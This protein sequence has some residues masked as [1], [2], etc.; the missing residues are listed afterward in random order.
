M[1]LFYLLIAAGTGIGVLA[2]TELLAAG[3]WL[4]GISQL[5]L[6]LIVLSCSVAYVRQA[7]PVLSL[8]FLLLN[9]SL[10]LEI[11][12][13]MTGGLEPSSFWAWL[14]F[15]L[16]LAYGPFG[17][18]LATRFP[19]DRPRL[20]WLAWLAYAVNGMAA[21]L[22][23]MGL[24]GSTLNP[25]DP[26]SLQARQMHY[27]GGGHTIHTMAPLFFSF[28]W[29]LVSL[30]VLV[31]TIRIARGAG[32]SR[33]ARQALIIILGSVLAVVPTVAFVPSML[34]KS[35]ELILHGPPAV[36]FGLVP[37][38]W[39]MAL[40]HPEFYDANGLFRRFLIGLGLFA[41]AYL[42]YLL[43]IKTLIYLLD[44]IQPSFAHDPALFGAALTVALLIRPLQSWMANQV[45]RLFFPHLLGF[46]T[47]LEETSQ[48]L[49]T[50]IIPAEVAALATQ[51]L[52][53][54]LGASGATLLV[55]D[56]LDANLA[57]M[58]GALTLAPGHP[59]WERALQ[60]GAPTRLM[61]TDHS[62]EL[63]LSAPLLMLPLRVGGRL[64]GIYAVGARGPGLEYTKS[65]LAQL[66]VL[67]NQMAVAVE[68]G[69]ALRKIDALSQ[70]ALAEVAERNRIARDIH[71]TIAQGLTAASLQLEVVEA[72][73][74]SNQAKA[75][76]ATERAQS[77]VRANLAEARRSVLELRAPL[78][79]GESLPAALGRLL[80][81]AAT[82]I[83][84]SSNFQLEGSYRGVEARVEQQ[85]FRI[86]QEALHNAVKYSSASHLQMRLRVAERDVTLRISD[87]GA[88]FDA[89]HVAPGGG[90]GG[91]GLTGMGE[92][93][94]LLGGD[95][96]VVSEPGGGT[97]VEA[98]IPLDEG[99]GESA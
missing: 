85:L 86:A 66:M 53:T 69:R 31:S 4:E 93:A 15:G 21:L 12:G 42:A 1:K 97:L 74:V 70:R 11:A 75:L 91:F 54:R 60:A 36:F 78:L 22:G 76:R 33:T 72:T 18:D 26:L 39:T 58:D 47:L 51:S 67:G 9:W 45:D 82:D 89:A 8:L 77:I 41:G 16:A 64:V 32:D 6:T 46:R 27:Q 44:M 20:R 92:R 63:G 40:R 61:A 28:F 84:A 38:A 30:V 35:M 13:H 2:S 25:M 50:M 14:F 23:P 68:N 59:V 17:L 80:K 83:G 48:A 79:G 24:L 81:E 5:L 56:D 10:C 7:K 52:P 3:H 29:L 19:L 96:H 73:M 99:E 94:R 55:L 87:D 62:T 90:R 37:F 95:L 34:P 88:G 57:T 65:E 98:I 71:D 49:A 43:L